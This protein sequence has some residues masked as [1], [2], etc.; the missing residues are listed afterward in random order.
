MMMG[1]GSVLALAGAVVWLVSLGVFK[2]PHVAAAGL[3]TG[4]L[5]VLGLGW[6]LTLATRYQTAG[7]G[8]AG[9][10]CLLAP[11]NLW[12]YVAQDLLQLDEGLWLPAA[13]LCGLYGATVWALR[14]PKF[15]LSIPVGLTAT[16]MLL[17]ADVA[18]GQLQCLVYCSAW[19]TGLGFAWMMGERLFLADES[20]TFTRK[21]FGGP[22]ARCGLVQMSFGLLP[23]AITRV[24]GHVMQV[25]PDGRIGRWALGQANAPLEIALWCL[26]AFAFWFA[27]HIVLRRR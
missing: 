24:V 20:A 6:W 22:L 8:L 4:T 19:I 2:D 3:A 21:R 10:A 26:G 13:A 18:P 5:G 15:M 16:V 11:L 7:K 25:S 23:L 12:F 17:V 1:L 14:D 27:G 9:L